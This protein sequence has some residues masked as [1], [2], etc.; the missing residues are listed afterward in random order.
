LRNNLS[1]HIGVTFTTRLVEQA[2]EK[3][4]QPPANNQ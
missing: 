4:W 3:L 2:M 1:R